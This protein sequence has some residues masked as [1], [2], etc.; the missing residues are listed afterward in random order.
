[1]TITLNLL[2]T[3]QKKK[4][5]LQKMSSLAKQFMIALLAAVILLTVIFVLAKI[6]LRNSLA[7]A[8][9]TYY[10]S[11]HTF[12]LRINQT[13]ELLKFIKEI[14]MNNRALSPLL[15]DIAARTPAN[16]KLSAL[17]IDALN[18]KVAL[19]GLSPTRAELLIFKD[20]LNKSTWFE[21]VDL[22]VQNLALKANI[23]F[24]INAVLL[25]K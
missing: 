4:V 7:K 13:N 1:M 5:R 19:R 2:S 25:A 23:D 14:K 15:T 16:V 17:E 12:N 6:T 9:E 11:N 8:S 21:P 18:Q 24:V 20:N 3:E 22:P 10:K